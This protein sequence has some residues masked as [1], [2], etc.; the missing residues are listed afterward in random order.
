[1]NCSTELL[2]VA[3]AVFR[4]D[5]IYIETLKDKSTAQTLLEE[6][7]I[8]KLHHPS[9]RQD[10]AFLSRSTALMKRLKMRENPTSPISYF[11]KPSHHLFP[12]QESANQ[13]IVRTLA[14][15]LVAAL[16]QAQEAEQSAKEYHAAM[17]AVKKVE[18]TCK[19]ASDLATQLKS[20][21]HRLEA[22]TE[23]TA[24]DGSPP[25]LSSEA[26]LP[27]QSHSVFLALFPTLLDELS[28][29][30]S[31]AGQTIL[32]GRSVIADLPRTGIDGQF[33]LDSAATVDRLADCHTSVIKVREAMQHRVETLNKLRTV[34]STMATLFDQLDGLRYDITDAIQKHMHKQQASQDAALLTPE[35]PVSPLPSVQLTP[36]EASTQL[37]TLASVLQ[38]GIMTPLNS[39]A[40]SIGSELQT[41]LSNCSAGLSMSL[42]ETRRIMRAWDSVQNQASEI[43]I[44]RDE[45]HALQM[46]SEHLKLRYDDAIQE[47]LEGRLSTQAALQTRAELDEQVALLKVDTQRFQDE[48]SSRV[49]FVGT[50]EP[51]STRSSP[52]VVRRRFS[53]STGFSLDVV[54]QAAQAGMP[55]DAAALDRA[56]R[57]DA[58]SYSILLAGEVNSLSQKAELFHLAQLARTIDEAVGSIVQDLEGANLSYEALQSSL[59][60]SEEN[61]SLD[62]LSS[63]SAQVDELFQGRG[64]SI[65]SSCIA[66]RD[67]LDQLEAGC[68]RCDPACEASMSLPRRRAV[69]DA[70]D[71]FNIW[72]EGMEVLSERVSDL[73]HLEQVRLM[74]LAKA[75]EEEEKLR[76]EEE[77]RLERKRIEKEAQEKAEAER[78]RVEAE[79]EA[80]AAEERKLAEEN[81]RIEQEA[82]LAAT[83]VSEQSTVVS[84][85][86]AE[87]KQLDHHVGVAQ[88]RR[89]RPH[90][91]HEAGK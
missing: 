46:R 28:Q 4:A 60:A 53:V 10:A 19:T 78:L 52:T 11:P 82:A 45:T 70:E 67:L 42:E 58:N 7:E 37:T 74:E 36:S 34:W 72:R 9:S 59:S 5:E 47:V 32:S 44:V 84:A 38:D 31:V 14:S 48:L 2:L 24:G 85:L 41:Y 79:V 66:A 86:G 33:I 91:S 18:N 80:R 87:S 43:S 22:G 62:H 6:I 30:I 54:R 90:P 61:L 83:K 16:D 75:R 35:S 8:A 3:Y 73:Q 81:V 55:F 56:V 26:C 40:P 69:E 76:I 89:E 51:G 71:R 39:V 20:L 1:M 68:S 23:S 49:P 15:E 64:H 77:G 12:D 25:D 63:I 21:A 50:V 17:E 88:Y 57:A 13:A 29:A 65:A 27:S